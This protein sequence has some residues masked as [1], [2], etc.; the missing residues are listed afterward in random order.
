MS[1]H[2]FYSVR[3]P[4]AL[5]L[6]AGIGSQALTQT[7]PASPATYGYTG[8]FR[9][10]AKECAD[11]F[12]PRTEV[13]ALSDVPLTLLVTE[14]GDETTVG[15][16]AGLDVLGFWVNVIRPSCKG[17]SRTEWDT[18]TGASV[19]VPDSRSKYRTYEEN[20]AG[21]NVAVFA[22]ANAAYTIFAVDRELRIVDPNNPTDP[23]KA[24]TEELSEAK[25]GAYL[26]GGV[27]VLVDWR[28]ITRGSKGNR[29]ALGVFARHGWFSGTNEF[30]TSYGPILN[31]SI[32]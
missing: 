30:I 6:T 10:G 23:D 2:P 26:S 15:P 25:V 8:T 17:G 12:H 9:E 24:T 4:L 3:L 32:F 13:R 31:I 5:I 18:N 7:V 29:L 11:Y 28:W 27:G 20:R 22:T 16:A 14:I 19:S 1:H 21:T